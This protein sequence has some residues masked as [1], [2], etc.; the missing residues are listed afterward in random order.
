MTTAPFTSAIGPIVSGH[1]VEQ[2]TLAVLR[3]WMPTYLAEAER[4]TGRVVGSLP[5]I[6]GWTVATTFDKWP[7]D[8]LPAIVLISPGLASPPDA[9][10]GGEYRARFMLGA[11]VIVSA[12]TEA[13][14]RELAG[15]YSAVMR[16]CLIQHQS[17][18]GFGLGVQWLDERYD[19]LN[20]DDG[21]SLA[22]GQVTFTIEVGGI[23]RRWNGPAH[24]SEPP[25]TPTDPIPEDA[26]V[27]TVEVETRPVP[28]TEVV[29]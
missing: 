4:Q 13:A 5:V 9:D 22:A 29:P 10:G 24:P 17:L 2:A 16:A 20:F 28:I 15:L 6:R 18:E 14:T 3:R 11:V 8:Q 19:D 27:E 26:T 12:A 25:A 7:E 23:A 21:R 1:D